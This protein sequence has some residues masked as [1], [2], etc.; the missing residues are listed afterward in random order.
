MW[1]DTMYNPYLDTEWMEEQF[2]AAMK[3]QERTAILAILAAKKAE[4]SNDGT[5]LSRELSQKAS[6]MKDFA[7][8]RLVSRLKYG[9]EGQGADAADHYLTETLKK[10]EFKSPIKGG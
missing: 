4:I 7:S 5:N 2:T 9:L 10:P 1:D 6:D 3:T 8:N